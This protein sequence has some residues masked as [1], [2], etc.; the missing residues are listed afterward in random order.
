MWKSLNIQERVY[1]RNKK[2]QS[3]SCERKIS[4]DST[5]EERPKS[6][7]LCRFLIA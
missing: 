4:A 7:V 3:M 2:P 5:G 6:I 1:P